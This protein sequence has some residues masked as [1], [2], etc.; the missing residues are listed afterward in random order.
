MTRHS[1]PRV[2]L[3]DDYP[4]FISALERLLTPS[5]EVVGHVT[6]GAALLEAVA[7]MRPDIVIVDVSL[8]TMNGWEACRHITQSSHS[9]VVMISAAEDAST[10]ELVLESGA[11]A[12]VR[13][14]EIV[15]SLEAAIK[16]ALV[17]ARGPIQ[18]SSR[19]LPRLDGV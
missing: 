6:D 8:P 3:A 18:P 17:D 16:K 2:L 19:A 10:Q 15:N 5:F 11:S 9:A 1:R 14:D 13:K 7:R 12:F 4:A